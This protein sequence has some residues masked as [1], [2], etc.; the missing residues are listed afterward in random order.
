MAYGKNTGAGAGSQFGAL[1]LGLIEGNSGAGEP[2]GFTTASSG[3]NKLSFANFSSLSSPN[4]WGG[5]LEG[6]DAH[7]AA[8]C[9]ADYFGTKQKSPQAISSVTNAGGLASGQYLAKPG[10]L[11]SVS[12]INP[13]DKDKNIVI[14]VDGNVNITSNITYAPRDT[15]TADS[16]P[17]FALVVK[18]SIYIAPNVNRLDGLYI[19]QPNASLSNAVKADSGVI[20]TC[21]QPDTNPPTDL[22]VSAN[23]R[24]KLTFNGAVIAKQVN[25]L[26][27]NGDQASAAVG[28]DSNSGNIAEVF[29]FTPEMVTGGGFFDNG[30][31]TYKIESLISLPPVF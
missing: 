20:W 6:S 16:V 25:L 27:V 9:T 19:A 26:R 28:E 1:A 7:Q 15:Y 23:C 8:H 22:Y 30:G 4:F 12:S 5:F 3:Y 17:K 13:V 14:F 11:L 18:G 21:H 10:S 2:Y 31:N 29:N 24:N